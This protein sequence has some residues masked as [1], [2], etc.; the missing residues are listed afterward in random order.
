M[1]K[2]PVDLAELLANFVAEAVNLFVQRAESFTDHLDFRPQTFRKYFEMSASL[3]RTGLDVL[4]EFLS[5]SIKPSVERILSHGSYCPRLVASCQ[6]YRMWYTSGL[7][8]RREADSEQDG[9]LHRVTVCLH[10]DAGAWNITGASRHCASGDRQECGAAGLSSGDCSPSG[11]SRPVG[12]RRPTVCQ[13]CA[14]AAVRLSTP[15]FT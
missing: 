9:S 7:S 2:P 6:A 8:D 11:I 10:I 13:A 4:S 15:S 1:Q 12:S 3:R 5:K 14:A